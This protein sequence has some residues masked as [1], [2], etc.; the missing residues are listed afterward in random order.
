V[1]AVEVTTELVTRCKGWL[2]TR[3]LT[4]RIGPPHT[5]LP[6]LKIGPGHPAGFITKRTEMKLEKFRETDQK[7]RPLMERP[8][9]VFGR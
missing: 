3:I 7:E 4:A 2:S 6:G 1:V 5:G 9:F 8:L